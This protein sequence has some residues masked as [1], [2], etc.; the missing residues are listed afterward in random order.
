MQTYVFFTR[1]PTLVRLHLEL[2][3]LA[4]REFIAI[5][6]M[7]VYYGMVGDRNWNM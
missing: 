4:R 1:S 6:R 2:L 3:V 7:G 5:R